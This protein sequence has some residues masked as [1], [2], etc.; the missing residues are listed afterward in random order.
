MM[1]ANMFEIITTTIVNDDIIIAANDALPQRAFRRINFPFQMHN[2]SIVG[3][4]IIPIHFEVSCTPFRIILM[5]GT[6]SAEVNS[7]NSI[8]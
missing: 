3:L 7:W 2:Y 5:I 6:T 4:L 1:I 8:S